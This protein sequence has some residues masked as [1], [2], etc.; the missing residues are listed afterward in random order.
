MSLLRRERLPVLVFSLA[1]LGCGGESPGKKAVNGLLLSREARFG[2]SRSIGINP[3]SDL[4]SKTRQEVY[5]LRKEF[6]RRHLDIAS[7]G[8]EPSRVFESIEDGKP[9]WGFAGLDHFGPGP[10]SSE[11]LSTQSRFI[12]NPYLLVGLSERFMLWNILGAS[13]EDAP[14]LMPTSLEWRSDAA[15]AT[16]RYE[17]RPYFDFLARATNGFERELALIGYNAR[18]FG[19]NYIWVD[20][21][22]SRNVAWQSDGVHAVQ[23]PQYIHCGGSCGN[24]STC[25][26]NM[27]PSPSKNFRFVVKDFPAA[28]HVSLWRE[29]PYSTDERADMTFVIEMN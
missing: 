16:A 2:G 21:A 25:C 15:R 22:K 17:V 11:G 6:V 23:I 14:R 10:K 1:V 28:V 9:W 13:G 24:P 4:N 12:N 7:P 8:Y 20:A 5:D 26:N 29:K 3:L 18:D 19:L 27:S